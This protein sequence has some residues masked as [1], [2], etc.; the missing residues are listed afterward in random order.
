MG[1]ERFS[2]LRVHNPTQ[3]KPLVPFFGGK[4]HRDNSCEVITRKV[5]GGQRILWLSPTSPSPSRNSCSQA[6]FFLEFSLFLTLENIFLRGPKD[7]CR[8]HSSSKVQLLYGFYRHS[9]RMLSSVSRWDS[10]P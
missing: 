4:K 8:C 9:S 6:S 7:K 5:V 10:I 2:L 3:F 1:E